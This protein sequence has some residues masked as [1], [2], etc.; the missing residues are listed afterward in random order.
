MHSE[1]ACYTPR[2][3]H[4]RERAEEDQQDMPDVSFPKRLHHPEFHLANSSYK[5]E[6]DEEGNRGKI[7]W[8]SQNYSLQTF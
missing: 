4:L 1:L 3:P 8:A 5:R 7:S 2:K 6:S